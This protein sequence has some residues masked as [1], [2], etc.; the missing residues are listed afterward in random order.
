MARPAVITLPGSKAHRSRAR[1]G[2]VP[3]PNLLAVA[4]LVAGGGLVAYVTMRVMVTMPRLGREDALRHWP[5]AVLGAAIV[6]LGAAVVVSWATARR[7]ALATPAETSELSF[8]LFSGLVLIQVVHMFEH[9]AQ[10]VQLMS[11]NGDLSR[12]H[13]MIG[14]LD[15]ETVHFGFDTALWVSLAFFVVLWRGE[16]RWLWIAFAFQT[17]H[18]VEHVYLYWMYNAE[19][20]LYAEGGLAGIMG[21]GGLVGSPLARPY[22]HFTYNLPVMVMMVLAWWQEYRSRQSSVPEPELSGS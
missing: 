13:G 2:T 15:F 7:R 20:A 5:V 10:V 16:N 17:I 21:A 19:P 4:A 14:R 22:L 18:Q 12:S 9:T 6:A 11:T 8:T 1:A 3:G